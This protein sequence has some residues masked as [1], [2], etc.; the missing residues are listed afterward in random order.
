MIGKPEGGRNRRVFSTRLAILLGAALL[1]GP[2]ASQAVAATVD[3]T[4]EEIR[5]L[6]SVKNAPVSDLF[7]E[8]FTT[9]PAF[10]G[11]LFSSDAASKISPFWT[12]GDFT[13]LASFAV[14]EPPGDDD[15]LGFY[16]GFQDLDNHYRLGWDAFDIPLV[17]PN[18]PIGV[19]DLLGTN[20]EANL[21]N[22]NQ[23]GFQE[24]V[25]GLRIIKEVDGINTFLY[26]D[27]VGEPVPWKRFTDYGVTIRR[28][29][30]E[31]LVLVEELGDEG[32]VATV[33][34]RTFVETTLTSGYVGIYT[35]SQFG[36]GFSN[37][38][39]PVPEPSSLALLIVSA[40]GGL[41]FAAFFWRRSGPR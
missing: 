35:D 24:G 16:F 22:P 32:P 27:P 25:H 13:F 31:L 37:V 19:G 23:V 5:D 33:F 41:L 38:T 34:N 21:P 4:A 40:A 15:L 18:H 7:F 14:N 1:V 39:V 20:G 26:Q 6:W 8:N 10:P 29:G 36:V 17:F 12:S 30:D 11:V 3:A 2:T 9:D 28:L